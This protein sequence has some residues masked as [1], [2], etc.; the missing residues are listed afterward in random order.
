M[1]F[2]WKQFSAL[3]LAGILL[4]TGCGTGGSGD[5]D[6]A[7][8]EGADDEVTTVD[9][10]TEDLP[11]LA[12]QN[13]KGGEDQEDPDQE[14]DKQV[15]VRQVDQTFTGD[16]ELVY[17]ALHADEAGKVQSPDEFFLYEIDVVKADPEEEEGSD[18]RTLYAV[19]HSESFLE[20]DG[21]VKQ[22]QSFDYPVKVDYQKEDGEWVNPEI[23]TPE[24][25]AGMEESAKQV[26]GGDQEIE[27]LLMRTLDDGML[28]REFEKRRDSVLADQGWSL[29]M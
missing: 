24:D 11:D 22:V 26:A 4:L 12:E 19:V 18:Q 23:T 16:E 17:K 15:E 8:A 14:K 20:N 1:K 13:D 7:Q 9:G 3:S 21:V 27:D 2:K 5:D 28:I 6:P 25:G 29:A 10:A